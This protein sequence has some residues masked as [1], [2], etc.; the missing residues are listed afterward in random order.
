MSPNFRTPLNQKAKISKG[1]NGGI[2]N[3]NAGANFPAY[4]VRLPFD[5]HTTHGDSRIEKDSFVYL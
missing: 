1:K 5:L 2:P 3:S 4:P